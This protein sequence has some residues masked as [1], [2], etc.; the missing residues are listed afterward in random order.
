MIADPMNVSG[1]MGSPIEAL[2]LSKQ[3]VFMIISM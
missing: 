3:V 1:S 2:N